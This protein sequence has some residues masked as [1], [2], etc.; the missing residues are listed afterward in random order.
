MGLDLALGGLV[1][2]LATRGW[3]RGFVL[4]AIRL[5]GLVSSVYVAV[6]V[7]DQ[8]K[9]YALDYLPTMRPDLVDRILWWGS[10]AV[11][12][13]VI[14]GVASLI[15]AVSRRQPYGL[16]EP[17]RGDQFAGLGLGAA[18]GLLYASFLVAGLSTYGE[19]Y[20]SKLDWVEGQTK[21][22]WA[23]EWNGKYHPAARLWDSP[24]VQQFRSHVQR[25]GIRSPASPTE[26][27]E[28]SKPMQTAS[29][30]PKLAVGSGK[31]RESAPDVESSL[32]KVVKGLQAQL[33]ALDL[34]D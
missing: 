11:S 2:F 3:L 15:V 7:R 24:P 4:Q 20:L 31:P 22:S 25:M 29:R 34:G 16:A 5:V 30:T 32:S 28:P 19:K 23:W 21:E 33:Q 12:Y 17:N 26:P 8:V 14:V 10:S 1:L 13:F 18:K 27:G 9:P 6:P